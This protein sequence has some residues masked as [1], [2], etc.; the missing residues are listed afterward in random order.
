MHARNRAVRRTGRAKR[1]WPPDDGRTRQQHCPVASND[2]KSTG[3]LLSFRRVAKSCRNV[4]ASSATF[5]ERSSGAAARCPT[6]RRG[7]CDRR[8]RR[9]CRD[10]AR[11][12]DRLD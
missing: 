3:G 5:A 10:G 1:S 2:S 8:R 11:C 12:S 4:T 6:R 9:R 7:R